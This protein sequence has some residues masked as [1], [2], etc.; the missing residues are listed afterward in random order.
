[1]D[2]NEGMLRV[3]LAHYNTQAE[4]DRIIASLNKLLV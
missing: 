3:G 2:E 4:V 1:L